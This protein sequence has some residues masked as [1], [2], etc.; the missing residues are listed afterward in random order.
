MTGQAYFP[1]M[2][3]QEVK[4]TLPDIN[5]NIPDELLEQHIKIV[6]QMKIRPLLGYDYLY[7]LQTQVSGSSLSTANDFIMTE[8]LEMILSL[9][10]Q[11]RLVMGQSYQ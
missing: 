3:A 7:Q 10:V 9:H 6:Q 1:I 2:T 8:Y 4:D 11:R 5:D